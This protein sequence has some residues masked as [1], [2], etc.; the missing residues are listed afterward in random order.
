[1]TASVTF[2]DGFAAKNGNGNY[3]RL[4]W[5]YYEENDDNKYFLKKIW[6]FSFSSLKLTINNE[7]M[8]FFHVEGCNG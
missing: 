4:L 7:M 2:F 3:C 6:S 8:V 1:M 5:F